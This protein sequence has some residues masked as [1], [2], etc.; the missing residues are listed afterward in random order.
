M[1]QTGLALLALHE[2]ELL[3]LPFEDLL[4][5]LSGKRFST[6]TESPDVVL[7]TAL[8]FECVGLPHPV[9]FSPV[10]RHS[11]CARLDVLAAS[12]AGNAP[13]PGPSST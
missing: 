4:S 6:L 11:V 1:F 13:G 12:Y 8:A 10:C 7:Q 3:G 2:N 5:T 9:Y